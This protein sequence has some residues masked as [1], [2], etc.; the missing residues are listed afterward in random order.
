MALIWAL[1]ILGPICAALLLRALL[2]RG[3]RKRAAFALIVF[4]A[5]YSLCVWGFLIEPKTLTVRHVEVV[6]AQWRGPPLRIGAISDTHIASPHM[7]VARLEKIVARMNAERPDIVLLLGDYVGGHGWAKERSTAENAQVMGGVAAFGALNAPLGKVAVIGNHDVWYGEEAIE[8]G[9]VAAGAKVARNTAVRIARPE[10]PFW[11]A[12]LAD[13]QSWIEKP[14]VAKAMA[15]V[16]DEAPAI[17]ISHYPDPW[18]QVPKSAALMVAGHSHCGQVNLPVVGRPVSASP[19]ARRW[20]C[21]L[22]RDGTR[23]LYVTGGIGV[24][25]LPVRFGAPPEIVLITLK[26][27]ASLAPASPSQ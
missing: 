25:I 4:S 15:A 16:T 12:G 8:Q 5:T 11:V 10:G 14:N 7:D 24:S 3:R 22:Y 6:S 27:E 1:T 17:V 23:Q 19:G 2:R 9:L 13:R 20:P 18:A 21:G 26:S